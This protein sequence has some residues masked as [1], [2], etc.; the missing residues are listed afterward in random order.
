[1]LRRMQDGA[2]GAAQDAG[3][4]RGLSLP[5]REASFPAPFLRGLEFN[6]PAHGTWNIVHIGML[7]PGAHQI[8]VCGVNCMRGVILTAAEM[9]ESER[10]HFV[11]LEESDLVEG[12]VEDVTIEGV[13]DVLEKLPELPPMVELFTVCLHRFLGCDQERI[14]GE[15]ERR[16]PGVVFARCTMEPITQKEGLTPDQRL[17]ASMM[18]V[19]PAGSVRPRTVS[20]LG[21]NFSLGRD[22]DLPGLVADAGWELCQLPECATFE[23]Y[24]AQGEAELLVCTFPRAWHG[25]QGTARRLGRP[26][27]YLPASFS[28]EEIAAQRE[29]LCAA[30]GVPAPSCAEQ[31]DACEA[32]LA[33]TQA[34]V[35]DTPICIDYAAH[36]RPLGLARLLLDHGFNVRTVYLD[37]IVPEEQEDF[38]WLQ[39]RHGDLLLSPTNQAAC[40]VEPRGKYAPCLAVG[41]IAA[42]FQQ[43]GHFVNLVEGGGLWGFAGIRG[44]LALMRDAYLT[45]KDTQDLIPR[46]GLGCGSCL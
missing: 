15:L 6:P 4:G 25:A 41:Q 1:M 42:W 46:K 17:R 20:A 44:M 40:R 2:Q 22:A 8:Y 30:L 11:I 36:P 38:A 21:G 18:D 10:F 7:A 24:L 31:A 33:K 5:I 16:F 39:E 34:L 23:E 26:C 13:A 45:V 27:L 29:E 14:Y 3:R 32:D 12:T 9:E 43:T 37:G 35:G 19:L 28:Y